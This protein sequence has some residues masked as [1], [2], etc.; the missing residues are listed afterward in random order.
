MSKINSIRTLYKIKVKETLSKELRKKF[1]HWKF[2]EVKK[3]IEGL[4]NLPN[5]VD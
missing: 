2:F 5:D 4:V 1:R 3:A